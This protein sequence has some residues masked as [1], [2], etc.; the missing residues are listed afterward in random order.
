M[1]KYQ[2]LMVVILLFVLVGCQE[3]TRSSS[4][5]WVV[6]PDLNGQT[7]EEVKSTLSELEVNYTI[8]TASEEVEGLE[9]MFIMYQDDSIGDIVNK[10]DLVEVLVYPP[11]TLDLVTLPDIEGLMLPEAATLFNNAV[12]PFATEM[13]ET[14]DMSL[15]NVVIEYE[16]GLE[17]GQLYDPK[18]A[19]LIYVYDYVPDESGFFQ[20]LD[21]DYTGPILSPNAF[22]EPYMNPQGGAIEVSLLRCTD[23]DTAKFNYPSDLYNAILSS[24]K[25]TRFLNMDTE[26][27]YPGGEEEWG[28]PASVYTCDLLTEATSIAIQTDPGDALLD[29]HG[30]LLAWIWVQLP[31]EDDYYLLNYM[32]VQQGLAQVKYEFGAGETVFYDD[33]SYNEWMHIAEDEA[34]L[35]NRGQWGSLLDFY[36]DYEHDQPDFSKWN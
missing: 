23:G 31:N 13:V 24:A 20:V 35:N 30:R 4:N 11:Y 29:A 6:L 16:T 26:E 3:T 1:K 18:S 8:I 34:I 21:L 22:D 36:W 32:V 14:N 9:G 28:K 10:D 15:D 2:I 25:S 27:T 7:V 5:E 17:A 19:V 33:I 12:L